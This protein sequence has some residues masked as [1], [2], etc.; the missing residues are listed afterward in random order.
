MQ[1]ARNITTIFIVAYVLNLIWEKSHM[2]L[3]DIA[4]IP[5]DPWWILIRATFWD[6]VIISGVY[7][8]VKTLDAKYRYLA[9]VIICLW[10]AIFIEQRAMLEGRWEYLDTMP[11]VFGMGLSP[12]IQLPLLAIVTYEIVRRIEKS[13]ESGIK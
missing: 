12:L 6:A 7:V 1:G 4:A 5:L 11:I 10:I 3:Y 2:A 8:L 9:T 13:R